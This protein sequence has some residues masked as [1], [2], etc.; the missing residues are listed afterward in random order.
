MRNSRRERRSIAA[1][2]AR[3]FEATP[4][5][6]AQ[7]SA[8]GGGLFLDY[9]KQR[10]DSYTL[11]LLLPVANL[12]QREAFV[13]HGNTAWWAA[14]E[15]RSITPQIRKSSGRLLRIPATMGGRGVAIPEPLALALPRQVT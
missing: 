7:F 8:E 13:A 5:R 2:R 6:A 14:R 3:W 10:I 9:S 15:Q 1:S 4:E 11:D 12:K